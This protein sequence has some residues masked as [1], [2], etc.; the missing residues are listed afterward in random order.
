MAL[1]L[2]KV[3]TERER[4]HAEV[5]ASQKHLAEMHAVASRIGNFEK[6]SSACLA[7]VKY[8]SQNALQAYPTQLRGELKEIMY[9]ASSWVE[10][11]GLKCLGFIENWLNVTSHELHALSRDGY[12]LQ[13]DQNALKQELA[14]AR[15]KINALLNENRQR[16]SEKY[17]LNA[18]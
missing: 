5:A 7:I 11:D 12:D 8:E 2:D 13:V 15:E 16:S 4:L 9:R 3:K 17:P 1:R 14:C 10:S 6:H 18:Q